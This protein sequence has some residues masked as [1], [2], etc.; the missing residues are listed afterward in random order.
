MS[1]FESLYGRPCRTP[2]SWSESG[3]RVI[4]SSDIVTEAKEKVKQIQANIIPIQSRQKSYADKRCNPLEFEMG[5]HV[6][7]RVSSM[8][9]VRRFGIK[10]KLA[11]RYIGS[12]SIIDKYGPTSYQVELPARLPGV[13]NVFHVFQLKR[14]MKPPAYVVIKDIIP[15]SSRFSTNKT[16]SHATRLLGY[17][18]SN[19]MTTPKTKPHGNM[20]SSYD[21]TTLSSFHRGNY[22]TPIRSYAFISISG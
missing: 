10:G 1:P 3:K 7:L 15:L 14:C 21:P 5:D 8:K 16:E 9:G 18:R 2:L 20:R 22:P 17:T 13:H 6:Y 4:F 11:P 12:Y 19:E